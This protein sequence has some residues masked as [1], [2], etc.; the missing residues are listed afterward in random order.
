MLAFSDSQRELI[1]DVERRFPGA[2][3]ASPR[4]PAMSGLRSALRHVATPWKPVTFPLDLQGT[5]FQK[6]VWRALKRVPAGHTAS[7]LDIARAIGSPTA[8]RAVAGACGANPISIA[9]PCH[10][11]V[12][13]D[14]SLSGYRWG[15]E[16]KQKLLALEAKH[17]ARTAGTA[18]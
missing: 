18:R 3:P 10:R 12:H 2:V 15:V 6:T 4:D 17:L 1:K 13:R 5:D 11:I 7:Y 9:V 16:R 8:S 14:G